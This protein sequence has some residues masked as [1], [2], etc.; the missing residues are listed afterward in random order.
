ML[1]FMVIEKDVYK[2]IALGRHEEVPQGAHCSIR[3]EPSEMGTES[4]EPISA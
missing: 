4:E 2:K 3:Q 1:T